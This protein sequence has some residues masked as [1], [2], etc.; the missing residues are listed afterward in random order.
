MTKYQRLIALSAFLLG[1]ST[2]AAAQAPLQPYNDT[3]LY[4]VSWSGVTVGNM[5]MHAREDDESY[6]MDLVLKSRGLAWAF[7][8][9]TS[10]TTTRGVKANGQYIPQQFETLFNLRGKTRHIVLTYDA[11]GRLTN[12]VNTPPEPE[13]K[14]PPVEMELKQDVIDALSTFFVHRPRIYEALEQND[15][16]FTIRM[17][18]GR[19][20]TD[21]QYLIHGQK[22]IGWNRS[23]TPVIHATLSRLPVAGYK[24]KE[25]ERIDNEQDP[26]VQIYF[27]DDGRLTPLKIEV[28]ADA[29]TFYA[30]YRQS[31]ETLAFCVAA[32]K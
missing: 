14:R 12:E 8:K 23:Q 11:K 21:L 22:T 15:K 13:W 30:N 26:G 5:I 20:L 18:D 1:L 29:G 19:R 27:S 9:H 10:T 24:D 6:A 31:C 3:A 32:T 25:L 16:Q 17:F 28:R 2:S 7:T 4:D